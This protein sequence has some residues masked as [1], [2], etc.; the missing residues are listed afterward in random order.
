[1][2]RSITGDPLVP[3]DGEHRLMFSIM[4][5]YIEIT[6]EDAVKNDKK[7]SQKIEKELVQ[8]LFLELEKQHWY[9]IAYSVILGHEVILPSQ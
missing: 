5:Y 8:I 9:H 2:F 4:V 3:F 7:R 1:M 6:R